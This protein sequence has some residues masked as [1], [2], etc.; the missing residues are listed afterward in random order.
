MNTGLTPFAG[1]NTRSARHPH[2]MR[3][4]L[5]PILIVL[6]LSG[7]G[8]PAII[9]A[10]SSQLAPAP[11]LNANGAL[12]PPQNVSG[13]FD[14]HGW[15]VQ[16]DPARGPVFS[17]GA[18]DYTALGS[19]GAGN[20]A[21]NLYGSVSA[22][23]VMG[24]DV[25]IGG[26]FTNVSNNGTSLGAADYIAKW[27]GSNWS[28]LGS[29]GAGDGALNNTVLSL[30]VSGSNLYVGGRFTNVNNNGTV[31][32]AADYIAKWDGANW[33]G[34]GSNGAGD[35]SL[36]VS[37]EVHVLAVS[38][39]DLYVGGPFTNVNNHGTVL[40]AADFIA[41]WDGTNWSSLG[42]NGAGG[43]SLNTSVHAIAVS[44]GAVY[45]GGSFG[46]V[47]NNGTILWEAD[48]VA[49]WDGANWSSLGPNGAGNGALNRTA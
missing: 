42:S 49:K 45:V 37:S 1:S 5:L 14:L 22:V 41:K 43:G 12:A 24:G 40:G 21:L 16:L 44:G 38:G 39:S 19:N 11:Y 10:G 9:S 26:S 33:S 15:N 28:S 25:Y 35:G 32:A 36:G 27:D 46:N 48:Y 30:A 4:P 6:L 23:A 20:G 18:S 7:L 2:R 34:L 17:P 47:N 13:S 29:N 8:L 31:L 3:M